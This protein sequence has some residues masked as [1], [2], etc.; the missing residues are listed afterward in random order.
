M[1]PLFAFSF[2]AMMVKLQS[3]IVL[4]GNTTWFLT[5]S[6]AV[7][8]WLGLSSFA[9]KQSSY[10]TFPAERRLTCLDQI[11]TYQRLPECLGVV[12]CFHEL[13]FIISMY[14]K[15]FV[16]FE[17]GKPWKQPQWSLVRAP[18]STEASAAS[19]LMVRQD[20][21]FTLGS[22]GFTQHSIWIRAD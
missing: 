21:G 8:F 10:C 2:A 22:H 11:E 18:K 13:S 9:T 1:L 14:F 19:T 20:T 12:R 7:S 4:V 5:A 16:Q 6:A 3:S 17:F 15:C